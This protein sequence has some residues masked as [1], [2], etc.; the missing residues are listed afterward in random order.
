MKFY[1]QGLILTI[2]LL[3]LMTGCSE[4]STKYVC[5]DGVV[6]KN[7]ALCADQINEAIESNDNVDGEGNVHITGTRA[8]VC[9]PGKYWNNEKLNCILKCNDKGTQANCL[10]T[11]DDDEEPSWTLRNEEMGGWECVKKE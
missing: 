1:A 5:P 6:V 11:C 2:G 7:V 3:M 4:S 10:I 8:I 9:D